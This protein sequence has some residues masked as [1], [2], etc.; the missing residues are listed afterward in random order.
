MSVTESIKKRDL[1]VPKANRWAREEV[2]QLPRW[3]ERAQLPRR[4][5]QSHRH[6][7]CRPVEQRI[8]Q[9]KGASRKLTVAL[10]TD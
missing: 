7:V 8:V 2:D 3:K 5:G 1:A 10:L 4:P 6:R 9:A